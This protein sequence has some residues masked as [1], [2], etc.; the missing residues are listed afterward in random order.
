M[1]ALATAIVGA[2]PPVV[3]IAPEPVCDWLAL[4][5]EAF[6]AFR[7]GRFF[8]SQMDDAI[9]PPADTVS[10]KIDA[11][12]AFGSGRH[13]STAGCLLALSDPLLMRTLS[14]RATRCVQVG[15][16]RPMSSAI[17]LHQPHD[18]S[19][20]PATIKDAVLDLGCGSGIL[21]I[22]AAKLW[23]RPVIAADLDP[24][25]VAVATINAQQNC[26]G[27]LV[28]VVAANAI[29]NRAMRRARPFRLI[30]ANILAH[31]LRQM[32]PAVAL[33]SGAGTVLVLAGF[34]DAD[35]AAVAAAYAGHGFRRLKAIRIDGWTALVLVR[36]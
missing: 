12:R 22:A 27:S 23:R 4:N 13:A 16:R 29:R 33:V 10:L 11:G 2:P 7:V 32:A 34:V 24:V 18:R 36:S 14:W 19:A 1:L 5:R 25:A 8:V 17:L 9:V 35:A 20:H 31:P 26:V 21:S 15:K 6:Q 3:T 28:R 30:L